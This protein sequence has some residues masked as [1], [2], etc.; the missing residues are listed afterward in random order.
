LLAGGWDGL[1]IVDLAAG[2]TTELAVPYRPL[3]IL[4]L[5]NDVG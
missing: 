2:T 5:P 3:D 4:V 1:T